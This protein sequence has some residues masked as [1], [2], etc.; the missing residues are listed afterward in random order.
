MKL[1]AAPLE[2]RAQL[3]MVVDLAVEDDHELAID[4][5]HRLLALGRKIDDRQPSRAESDA[6]IV[7]D[8]RAAGVGSAREHALRDGVE[9]VAANVIRAG[10]VREDCGDAAHR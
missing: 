7:G 10:F 6:M 1:R 5:E 9:L 8:P 2:S 4:V 3:A